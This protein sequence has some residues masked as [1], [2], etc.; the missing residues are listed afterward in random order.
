M[1]GFTTSSTPWIG[2]NPNYTSIN[3][4]D[5]LNNPMSILHFYKKMIL[6]RKTYKTFVYGTYDLILDNHN[7]VYGYTRTWKGET[8]LI[9]SNLYNKQVP[10][11]LPEHLLTKT[12]QLILQNYDVGPH[13]SIR[14]IDMKPYE[15]RVY[16]LV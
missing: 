8:M 12:P 9:L 13:S 3:V 14:A 7:E 10:V 2:V 11:Y 5:Q 1:A 6:L 16:R 4:K 15:T